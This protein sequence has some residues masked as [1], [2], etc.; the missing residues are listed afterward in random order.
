MSTIILERMRELKLTDA[1]LAERAG[2]DRSMVNRVKFGKA[3]PSLP[4]AVKMAA[5]LDLPVSVFITEEAAKKHADKSER[6]A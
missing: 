6:A 2:C 4:T 3:M 1:A 5:A